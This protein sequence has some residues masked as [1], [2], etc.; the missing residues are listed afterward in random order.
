MAYQDTLLDHRPREF[1]LAEPPSLPSESDPSS[2]LAR[3]KESLIG[4]ADLATSSNVT[5]R[6][7]PPVPNGSEPPSASRPP[8]S[9]TSGSEETI[10]RRR[11]TGTRT[12]RDRVVIQSSN[13]S[14]GHKSS[15]RAAKP[16]EPRLPSAPGLPRAPASSM[17]FSSVPFYGSP[18]NQALRAHT[19]TL[20]GDRI[21]II[22]GVDRQNCWRGV[23]WYDTESYMWS[24]IETAGGQFPPLRAHTTTLVGDK[25]FI[26]GGGD[27]PTYSNDIWILDTS[28]HR[29]SRP[30]FDPNMPLPPPRRAHTTVLYQHYLVVFGGGNGQAALN[31]VWA[32]DITDLDNLVWLEWKTKGDVPQKKGYHTANLIGDKMVVFGGSDG[33]ASFAD[34]HVLNLQTCVWTLVNTDIKHNRLSH[35]STQVGSY[36]FVIGGHNGQAYAQD[37]LLFNLVTLQWE[38]KVP[39]GAFP[40]G[41]GYHVALLHDARIFISGGYN[42]ETVFDDFWI[43][44]LSASAYLPQVTTF[45]VDETVQLDSIKRIEDGVGA[46]GYD[47]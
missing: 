16:L 29:F 30:V 28:T 11:R 15:A 17:Y 39:R 42:G 34:V 33:H 3:R 31:D 21:W 22:G 2:S 19:G 35:T 7:L 10:T 41:R 26:F 47:L 24:T 38:T 23:A 27:G 14:K 4:K 18:P 12:E 8:E 43:L 36:L 46:A 44:D 6:T 1:S 20:V 45:E 37:V 13:D 25:L 9:G 40:P 32:L 5:T